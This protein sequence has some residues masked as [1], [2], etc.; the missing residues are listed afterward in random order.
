MQA[1]AFSAFFATICGSL[2]VCSVAWAE[3]SAA[4]RE[5]ARDLMKEGDKKFAAK[6]AA[7]A[8]RAYEEAHK[9]VNVP[10]TGRELAR[11]QEALGLFVEAR[12]T[13]SLVS[14][15]PKQPNEPA[16]FTNAR[17]ECTDVASALAPKIGTLRI[18]I[19]GV[20]A[21]L[22]PEITIDGVPIPGGTS[23]SRRVNPGRHMVKAAAPGY[24]ESRAETTLSEGGMLDVKLTLTPD[25]KPSKPPVT[26]VVTGDGK[27]PPAEGPPPPVEP[28]TKQTSPLVYVGFGLGGVGLLAG[29][30]TGALAFSKASSAKDQCTSNVCPSGAQSDIDGSKTMGTI[31]T[32]GFGVGVAGVAVGVVGLLISKPATAANAAPARAARTGGTLVPVIGLGSAGLAG[33]F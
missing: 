10:T 17:T 4:D 13:C 2:A 32:I 33:T 22:K 24:G 26:T 14:K 25:G 23:V 18:V 20:S 7:G 11:A 3:P 8:M 28:T 9:L 1:R 31:S 16:P 15:M 30:I 21:E 27:T 29:G 19:E 12:D 6:D 5:T